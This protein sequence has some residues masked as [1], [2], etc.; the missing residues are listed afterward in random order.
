MNWTAKFSSIA[1]GGL[2]LLAA[3]GGGG[4]GSDLDQKE[5]V[6]P[7][8]ENGR[9]NAKCELN[10]DE[11]SKIMEEDIT[12]TIDCL[13]ANLDLFI[14]LVKTDRP[15][16]LN[17]QHLE[18]YIRRN[19]A[20]IRP[21][22]LK[23]MKAV[24][25]LNYLVFG[26]Q[27]E[28]ISR[29]NVH[30]LVD[31]AKL[32]NK[33]A[34][35]NFKPIFQYPGDTNFARHQI[36]R[37]NHI[38]PAARVV[39]SGLKKIFSQNRNGQIHSLNV[40]SIIEAFTT[41]NNRIS[42]EKIKKVLF[43]KKVLLSGDKNLLTH[44]ELQKLIQNFD[45]L[46]LLALDA[47][48]F[49][50][51][52]LKQND[53][54]QYLKQDVDLLNS[55]IFSRGRSIETEKLF[56]VNELIDA[57]KLFTEDGEREFDPEKYRDLI[58]EAK[59]ILMGG[60]DTTITGK[61]FRKLFDHLISVLD[62]GIYFHR[63]WQA[64]SN[65]LDGARTSGLPV[66]P[67]SLAD[68][69]LQFPNQEKRVNDFIRIV[70]NYRFMR[71]KADVALYDYKYQRNSNGVYEAALFEYAFK[72][73]FTR[74]GCP[75]MVVNDDEG[76]PVPCDAESV[77][78]GLFGYRRDGEPED[79]Y[80]ERMKKA[81]VYMKKQH[82]VSLVKRFRKALIDLDLIYPGRETKTAETIT[83]LGSLFQYQSDENKV[84][85]L[86]EA[87]EFSTSLFTS[88]DL[89]D[90]LHA[91]YRTKPG[92]KWDYKNSRVDPECFKKHYWEGICRIFPKQFPKLYQSLGAV[93]EENERIVCK[94]PDNEKNRAYLERAIVAARTCHKYPDGAKEEIY[95]SK[96]DMMSIFLA[97]M[98]IETTVLRWDM[99]QSN[100]MEADEVM[101]AYKI[102]SPAL[103]G[104]LE[105]KSPII[106]SF[107]KQIYQ[108]LVKYEEVPNE[109]DPTSIRKF[110]K[111]LLMSKKNKSSPANRKTI[112]SIL[113]AIS[114]QGSPNL[115]NCAYL[116]NPDQIP[117]DYDPEGE[118]RPA[119]TTG[120]DY[121][122]ELIPYLDE[123]E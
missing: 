42:M 82:V 8:L 40:P 57:I 106:K 103:D 100:I 67:D 48:R 93:V 112:A 69:R 4:T 27:Q 41:E 98:H 7:R 11:F 6:K 13:G 85:D 35:T 111:F 46:V 104:F 32:F 117:E 81:H 34:A 29:A 3:C 21:E 25:E 15:G 116:R 45:S 99:N 10:I 5:V 54:I 9:F 19:R 73:A 64:K 20:E 38:G 1:M 72:L 120:E 51:V 96:G 87:A 77:P 92:C 88:I 63:F 123:A 2:L 89:S 84:F 68:L 105:D 52:E 60:D 17:R 12:E 80:L 86:N 24:F 26:D 78:Y 62:T 110:I 71:G 23:A 94:I 33:E 108:Y 76:K 114:E 55:M 22:V 28:F 102:Y 66:D 59:M 101:D 44:I 37:E 119:P 107:K 113:V 50:K 61:D 90:D 39:M 91:F 75:A 16:Y 70:K 47:V 74:Y 118:A 56:T 109:K 58:K 122:H 36:F 14:K 49:S 79:S 97:M 121:S 30:A 95:Y 65:E 115:F 18:D 43:V 83:L 31:F 53:M